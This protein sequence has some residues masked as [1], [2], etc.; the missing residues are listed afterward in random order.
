[1]IR[2]LS[3]ATFITFTVALL[4]AGGAMAQIAPE[5]EQ[6]EELLKGPAEG[7][8]VMV[9]LLRF[10]KEADAPDE[11]LSGQEAYGRYGAQMV[12]WVTSQGA[13]LIWSGQVDS[14][15]IGDTDEYFHAIALM[16]YPSRAEFLRIISDPR[17]AEYSVH[18]TAGLDMQWLIATT[19]TAELAQAPSEEGADD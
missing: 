17:V 19:T 3:A 11:G 13:R 16:E 18:R 9:N 8:V 15:V 6:I 7:P 5:P 14:M 10:K 12:Q 2:P 1:M 4:A